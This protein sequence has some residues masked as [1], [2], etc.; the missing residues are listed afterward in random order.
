MDLECVLG[1]LCLACGL[2]HVLLPA[3][4]TMY[5]T[6]T[7]RCLEDGETGSGKREAGGGRRE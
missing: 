2:T 1:V 5:C 7:R 6:R 4:L 3:S